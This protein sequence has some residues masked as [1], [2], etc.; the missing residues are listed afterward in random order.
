MFNFAIYNYKAFFMTFNNSIDFI[1][2]NAPLVI[3]PSVLKQKNPF[4]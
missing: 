4:L 3:N 2:P 1:D